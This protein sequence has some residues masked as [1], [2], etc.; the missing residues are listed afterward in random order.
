MANAVL[1]LD[2][3]FAGSLIQAR[4]RE[5]VAG[6]E[7]VDGLESLAQASE[8][9]VTSARAFVIWTGDTFDTGESGRASRASQVVRQAWTVLLAVRNAS[10]VQGDARN[11]S[12]GPLLSAA[13]RALAG[14][15]PEGALRPL[16]RINGPRPNYQ[17]S[18]GLYPLTFA[19]DLVI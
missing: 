3:L 13:H 10:Q 12:A 7:A 16:I 14:W 4:L 19:L 9:H 8:A 15:S 18:V 11:A 5:Q 1:L 17:A 2:Y 6:L